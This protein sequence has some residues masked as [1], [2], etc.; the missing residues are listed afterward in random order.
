VARGSPGDEGDIQGA[1]LAPGSA[2][3]DGQVMLRAERA[4]SG[5]GRTYEV[6]CA[7][8]DA[9]GLVTSTTAKVEVPHDQ[10]ASPVRAPSVSPE[11]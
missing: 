1:I 2:A 9:A 11:S 3:G 5:P 7:A 4:G 8:T 6:T 10:G